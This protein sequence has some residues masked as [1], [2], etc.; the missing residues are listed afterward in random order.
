LGNNLRKALPPEEIKATMHGMR[1]AMRSWGEDQTNPDGTPRFAE[2]D[3]E[4]AIGHVAGF[5]TTEVARGYSRQAKRISALIP[6]FN[7]WADLITGRGLP[8]DVIPF[9]RRASTGG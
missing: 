6:I 4:R 9:R 8:A 1:T 2:K 7:G 5:G 3:L